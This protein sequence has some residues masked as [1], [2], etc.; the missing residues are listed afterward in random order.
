MGQK[1][2]NQIV[3]MLSQNADAYTWV[4][5]T[6]RA[7]DAAGYQLATGDAVMPIGGFM[8]GDPS[9]TLAQFQ[10]YVA[11]NAVRYFIAGGGMDHPGGKSGSA[12]DITTWVQKNFTAIDVGGTTV[13]DLSS[14]VAR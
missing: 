8:G 3:Q 2:S 10:R 4:A 6:T 7:N 12:S 1:V 13:Y 9:P 5:A 11:D 14:P